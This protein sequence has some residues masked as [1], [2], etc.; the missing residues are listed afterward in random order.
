MRT[1]PHHHAIPSN[2][3]SPAR[4]RPNHPTVQCVWVRVC[5]CL[6]VVLLSAYVWTAF[7]L[8]LSQ[9][10]VDTL[11]PVDRMP[12]DL[13]VLG[14]GHVRVGAHHP[15]GRR[16]DRR[17]VD[18]HLLHTSRVGRGLPTDHQQEAILVSHYISAC[19][20]AAWYRWMHSSS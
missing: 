10:L 11:L 17:R 3:R 15:V 13:V 5:V 18:R 20:C 6:C 1:S 16:R 4:S 8:L 7:D 9:L 2:R 12:R 14:V 19:V